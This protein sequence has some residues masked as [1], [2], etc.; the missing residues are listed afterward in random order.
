ML[1]NTTLILDSSLELIAFSFLVIWQ[2]KNIKYNVD[3]NQWKLFEEMQ[4]QVSPSGPT[5]GKP[6][7]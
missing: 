7:I 3:I 2:V 5:R 1:I 6:D 4:C